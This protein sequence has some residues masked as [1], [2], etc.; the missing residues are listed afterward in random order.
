MPPLLKYSFYITI[1][2]TLLLL[3]R[4]KKKLPSKLDLSGFKNRPKGP[5]LGGVKKVQAEVVEDEPREISKD[6]FMYKGKKYNA[7]QALGVPAGAGNREI[8]NAFAQKAKADS[9]NKDFYFK[10]MKTLT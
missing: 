5:S 4:K 6:I 3:Y 9:L 7:W 8:K 2:I 10:A 1:F